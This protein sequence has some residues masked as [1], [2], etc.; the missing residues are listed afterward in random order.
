MI[1]KQELIAFENKI[2]I[3]FDAGE[4]PYLIHFSGG[5]EDQL[6][7][8]FKDIKE[9]DWIFSTHRSHYHYLLAGG[10]PERLEKLIEDGYSMFVFDKELNFY[11][12]SI[13]CAT[14]SI[15]AGVALALKRKGSSQKVWCFIGDGAEDEGHFC[16]ALRYVNCWD[17]PC[18][19]IVEDNNRSVSAT[20]KDRWNYEK[21]RLECG[22]IIRYSYVP[23]RPHG[24][25]GTS[26]WLK[27]TK[28]PNVLSEPERPLIPSVFDPQQ[29]QPDKY[30]DAV[31][32]SMELLAKQ[33]VIFIGYNVR[34]GSA[35]G[36]LKNVPEN[37]RIETPLAENLMAGLAIGLSLEG[38]RPLL[39]FE[40]HDFIFNA[41]DALIN[42]VDK[43][44]IISQGQFKI[45]I[46][47]RA[48]AGGIK[49]FYSGLTHTS[50][51]TK[52]FKEMFHF[53]V[54]NPKTP[55][56]VI[57]AYKIA[58]EADYPVLIS[59]EKALY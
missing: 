30:F 38:Y 18:K 33:G 44:D 59:E 42:Q 27:F 39:F 54:Y 32:E 40:R 22:D 46:I 56:E 53:P 28:E 11:S 2:A 21:S 31:K 7:E 50:N 35:Y 49:P 41:L 36:T 13:V 25:S 26:G 43:I 1:T 52:L 24:G 12:S 8:I 14:P 45:P 58:L 37:Q 55:N 15:A 34:Y 6:I 48:V 51:L 47:I 5:N 19:F 10:S 16:E 4:L 23:T 17:L 29:K 3:R 57:A 9:G 20:K